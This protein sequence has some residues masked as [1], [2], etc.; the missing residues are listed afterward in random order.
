M[1][2]TSLTERGGDAAALRGAGR[3]LGAETE[4][5]ADLLGSGGGVV[6][7][8][9]LWLRGRGLV[10]RAR[11]HDGGRKTEMS[12]RAVATAG[13][14]H[15]GTRDSTLQ[16]VCYRQCGTEGSVRAL[17]PGADPSSY[18]KWQTVG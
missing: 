11:P 7:G 10:A 12:K 9:A 13:R 15:D 8:H 14:G 2:H 6:L 5:C 1:T 3:T 16:L 17:T 18:V 4:A